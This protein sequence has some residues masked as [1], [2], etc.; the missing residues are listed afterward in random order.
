MSNKRRSFCEDSTT[1]VDIRQHK[2]R[3]VSPATQLLRPRRAS[4]RTSR[5]SRKLWLDILPLELRCRI[6]SYV[7]GGEQTYSALCLAQTNLTQRQAVLSTLSYKLHLSVENLYGPQWMDVFGHETQTLVVKDDY[8]RLLELGGD[9]DPF[10]FIGAPPLRRV[11]ILD[12][13]WVLRVVAMSTSV[14]ELKISIYGLAPLHLLQRTLASLGKDKHL[15]SLELE[16][17]VVCK[18]VCP[19][20]RITQNNPLPEALQECSPKLSVLKTMCIYHSHHETPIWRALVLLPTLSEVTVVSYPPEFVLGKLRS[21]RSV[22]I[23]SVPNGFQLAM[24]LGRNVISLQ[25]SQ[26]LSAAE[27]AALSKCPRL[28]QLDIDVKKGAEASLLTLLQS[29][30]SLR[31]LKLKWPRAQEW[32][33]LKYRWNG[34]WFCNANGNAIL[35]AVQ[36]APDL[37]ELDLRYVRIPPVELENIL[38]GIGPRLKHY[39]T[40]IWDQDE[41]PFDHLETLIRMLTRYCSGLRSFAVS[42]SIGQERELFETVYIAEEPL[43]RRKQRES[44]LQYALRVL[45]RTAPMVHTQEL[46]TFIS[47]MKADNWGPALHGASDSSVRAEKRPSPYRYKTITKHYEGYA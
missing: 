21:I 3:R 39:G 2:K 37:V 1:S 11:E 8:A 47:S 45:K 28:L 18:S 26:G 34:F 22:R 24:E 20:N 10:T 13:P 5:K 40:S 14:R 25:S 4:R 23:C 31:S 33:A 35:R 15:T 44:R 19:F 30:T 36:L 17:A 41:A 38:L 27:V 42:E 32:I 46:E 16:C 6:A 43:E 29:A 12:E 7:S 9:P